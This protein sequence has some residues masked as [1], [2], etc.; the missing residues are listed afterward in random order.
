M[1]TAEYQLTYMKPISSFRIETGQRGGRVEPGTYKS[2]VQCHNQYAFHHLYDSSKRHVIHGLSCQMNSGM[3]CQSWGLN[4]LILTLVG[5]TSNPTCSRENS[6][7]A[8]L[9]AANTGKVGRTQK[10]SLSSNRNRRWSG[11]V[12]EQPTPRA[13]RITSLSV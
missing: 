2:W 1:W 5:S 13:Y 3:A 4:K 6:I 12:V 7:I 10:S 9:K 8:P 11:C